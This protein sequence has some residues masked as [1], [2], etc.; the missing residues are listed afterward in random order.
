MEGRPTAMDDK[1]VPNNAD[2]STKAL[3]N[4]DTN[5]LNRSENQGFR[6]LAP[7][8]CIGWVRPPCKQNKINNSSQVVPLSL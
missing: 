8:S 3:A 1:A 5:N 4:T 7:S 6:W 2:L